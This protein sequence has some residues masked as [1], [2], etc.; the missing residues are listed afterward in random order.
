MTTSDKR[1]AT[2]PDVPTMAEAGV[3]DLEVYFWQAVAA[4]KG[5]PATVK[6]KLEAELAAS[7]QSPDVKAKFEAVGFDVVANDGNQFAKFLADEI[8]RWKAVIETG[9][10]TAE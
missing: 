1:V 9:K 2:L 6:A 5:L 4:P 7:A 3:K 8:A 10:I